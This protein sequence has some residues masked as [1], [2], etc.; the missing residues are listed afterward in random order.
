MPPAPVPPAPVL[1]STLAPHIAE[2]HKSHQMARESL[3]VGTHT[4]ISGRQ[5]PQGCPELRGLLRVCPGGVHQLPGAPEQHPQPCRAQYPPSCSRLPHHPGVH[6]VNAQVG[7]VQKTAAQAVPPAV[8]AMADDGHAPIFQGATMLTYGVL[9]IFGAHRS[10]VTSKAPTTYE[11]EAAQ[12][13]I[14]RTRRRIVMRRRR[15][16]AAARTAGRHRPG[17]R[18]P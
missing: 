1:T 9:P 14:R 17:G 3:V 16:R 2:V 6:V 15:L 8:P 4:A 7:V 10:G 5:R 13:G 11:R 18:V 12:A